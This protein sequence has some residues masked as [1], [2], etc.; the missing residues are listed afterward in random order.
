MPEIDRIPSLAIQIALVG[1]MRWKLFRNSLRTWRGRLEATSLV[2]IGL[3]ISAFALGAESVWEFFVF[4]CIK[5]GRAG[6][7]ALPFWFVFIFWQVLPLFVVA[8]SP[9]FE[10]SNLLR[11]P[12]RFSSLFLVSLIY[13]VFDPFALAAC[14]WL[15]CMGFGI[16]LGDPGTFAVGS[17]YPT[18][19]CAGESG[20]E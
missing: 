17:A 11:F 18:G 13:G 1:R 2:V 7:L 19:F 4:F 8:S 15:G 9:Q 20:S 5:S 3:T 12:F 6:W 10:F 16:M 14:F